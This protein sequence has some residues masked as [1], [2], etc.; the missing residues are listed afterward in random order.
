M[1]KLVLI[2]ILSLC[3]GVLTFGGLLEPDSAPFDGGTESQPGIYNRLFEYRPH[4]MIPAAVLAVVVSA[5]ISIAPERTRRIQL[6]KSILDNAIDELCG[7]KKRQNRITILLEV[8]FFR[9]AFRH[10]SDCIFLDMK[11]LVQ[12]RLWWRTFVLGFPVPRCR[13]LMPICREGLPSELRSF[14]EIPVS[15]DKVNSVAGH[16]Y[17][18]GP[19]CTHLPSLKDIALGDSRELEEL[20]S[21]DQKKV[22]EYMKKGHVSNFHRLKRFHRLSTFLW[23]DLVTNLTGARKGVIIIDSVDPAINEAEISR[24]MVKYSGMIATVLSD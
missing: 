15:E 14:V 7:N 20:R 9:A 5:L 2:I 12:R 8:G 16:C 17:L 6:L 19:Y 10:L 1:R 4:F 24:G 3:Q 23:G 13:Y 22:I 18:D 21:A 11:F